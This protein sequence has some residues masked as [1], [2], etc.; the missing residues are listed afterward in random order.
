MNRVIQ[1]THPCTHHSLSTVINIHPEYFHWYL[2]LLLT[3]LFLQLLFFEVKCT[4]F[5]AHI[6][7][8]C[9]VNVYEVGGFIVPFRSSVSL[10][11]LLIVLSSTWRLKSPTLIMVLLV[12]PFLKKFMLTYSFFKV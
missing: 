3:Y 1:Y 9:S 6:S 10:L 2:Y 8:L 11:I 7:S 5:A 12:P 4:N